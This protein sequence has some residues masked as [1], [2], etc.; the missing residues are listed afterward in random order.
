MGV[1]VPAVH[2][3]ARVLVTPERLHQVKERVLRTG[4]VFLQPGEVLQI[5]TRGSG[6]GDEIAPAVTVTDYDPGTPR[7]TCLVAWNDR[8][9]VTI[10][11]DETDTLAA[12]AGP[13]SDALA[14]IRLPGRD[15]PGVTLNAELLRSVRVGNVHVSF[16][17]KDREEPETDEPAEQEE[18]L[19]ETDLMLA[20]KTMRVEKLRRARGGR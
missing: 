1:H 17:R 13:V 12:L 9:D 14:G 8:D 16:P 11:G 10:Y 15:G 18:E 2:F 4:Q 19:S 20:L 5:D 6:D 7:S 3:W